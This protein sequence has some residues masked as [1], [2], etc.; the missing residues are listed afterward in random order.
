M[1]SAQTRRQGLYLLAGSLRNFKVASFEHIR[2][3]LMRLVQRMYR[4]NLWP[5]IGWPVP[6]VSDTKDH[7]I[8]QLRRFRHLA[9]QGSEDNDCRYR[10]CRTG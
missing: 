9:V 6:S 10:I 4:S 2:I 8:L 3:R 5:S 7:G 1:H